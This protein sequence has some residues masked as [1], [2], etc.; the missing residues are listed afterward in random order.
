MKNKYIL[1]NHIIKK[2]GKSTF[3][4]KK[5]ALIVKEELFRKDDSTLIEEKNNRLVY[6]KLFDNANRIPEKINCT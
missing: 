2:S 1:E 3:W 6:T 5:T 4:D